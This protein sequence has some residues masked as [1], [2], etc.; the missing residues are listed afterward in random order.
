MPRL[1]HVFSCAQVALRV[2]VT[3]LSVE[4]PDFV[5]KLANIMLGLL[6]ARTGNDGKLAL[7]WTLVRAPPHACVVIV[8]ALTSPS[9]VY[10]LRRLRI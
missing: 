10:T 9:C 4:D 5:G 7:C 8:A 3:R 1:S 6:R 2:L